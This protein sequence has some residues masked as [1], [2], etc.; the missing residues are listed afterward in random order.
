MIRYSKSDIEI[1]FGKHLPVDADDQELGRFTFCFQGDCVV[2]YLNI[3]E[4]DNEAT[5]TVDH[6]G[7]EFL[8]WHTKDCEELRTSLSPAGV[9][10]VHIL[11]A[12]SED[13]RQEVL[14]SLSPNPYISIRSPRIVDPSVQTLLHRV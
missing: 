11:C 2:V 10:E 1:V 9:G 4:V 8:Y 7:R 14:I 5:L 3:V 6:H 13:S 12:P